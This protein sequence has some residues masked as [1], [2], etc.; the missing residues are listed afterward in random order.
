MPEAPEG[1]FDHAGPENQSWLLDFA[2]DT[3][4]KLTKGQFCLGWV[5]GADTLIL[6]PSYRADFN[7][8]QAHPLSA[9]QL[10]GATLGQPVTL[11]TTATTVPFLGF[12][13]TA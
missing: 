1:A 2:H 6:S 11:T 10:V 8:V 3:A 4:S 9:A 13:R 5:P 7:D 12:V